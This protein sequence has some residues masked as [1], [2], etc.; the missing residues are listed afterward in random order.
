[1]EL[2]RDGNES[3]AG[4]SNRRCAG[5]TGSRRESRSAVTR[6]GRVP[7][8]TVRDA[9]VF[10][11]TADHGARLADTVCCLALQQARAK[12]GGWRLISHDVLSV[13]RI[14][15]RAGSPLHAVSGQARLALDCE[16]YLI[17]RAQESRPLPCCALDFIQRSRVF[18]R[19]DVAQFFA[20]IYGAHD[21]AHHFR[22]SRFWDVADE[23]EFLGSERFAKLGRERVF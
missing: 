6:N 3:Q 4:N 13:T 14:V 20:K 9:G 22:V 16:P 5:I 1:M 17:R 15:G 8:C 19:G 2:A 18:Q 23:Q 12:R 10:R 11:T 7:S 21:A